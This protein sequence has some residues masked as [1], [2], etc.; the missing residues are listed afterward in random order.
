MDCI[1]PTIINK[2]RT[3]LLDPGPDIVICDEGHLLKN[4]SSVLAVAMSRVVTKRRIILTGTPMQNNLREYYCMVN[5]VKPS[6]LG[7]YSEYSNR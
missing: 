2:I 6:L 5:F 7:T 4:D 3:A 1:R